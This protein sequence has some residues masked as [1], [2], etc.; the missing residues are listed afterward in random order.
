M[1]L[2]LLLLAVTPASGAAAPVRPLPTGTAV[3]YQLGGVR[4]VP[5]QVGIVVRDRRAPPAAGRYSV[6]YVNGF[7][8]QP[9]ERA[10]WRR[11]RSLVLRRDGRPVVDRAWGEWLLDLRTPARRRALAT[12]VG[13]WVRG[14]ARAGYAAVEFDNLDSFTRSGELLRRGQALA[15][16]RLLVRA[17]HRAGLAAG[18]KNAP[19]IDGP[20]LGFDF[21]VAEECAR[22]DE[23]GRYVRRYGGRVLAI[24][25]RRSDFERA[26]RGY[27]GTITVVLRD[28]ALSP[29]G[30][31]H[32]CP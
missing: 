14:C 4:D 18:Q 3:D 32:W 25:Y 28:R 31:R 2:G 20:A 7:Q 8:T 11:H 12:I 26:C 27:G 19:E 10:F 9:D 29:T 1:V 24:E 13:R 6:C 5:E 17:A 21:A 16:A 22:Y 30:V 23:C 15:Y